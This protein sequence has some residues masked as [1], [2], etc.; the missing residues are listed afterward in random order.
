MAKTIQECCKYVFEKTGADKFGA[1][2]TGLSL[3]L[4]IRERH[5]GMNSAE[6]GEIKAAGEYSSNASAIRQSLTKPETAKRK[7][8][9]S[10]DM[11]DEPTAK[12]DPPADPAQV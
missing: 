12:V 11:L 9:L 2:E 4:F 10:L 3:A 5:P 1:A 6:L 8:S 7:R